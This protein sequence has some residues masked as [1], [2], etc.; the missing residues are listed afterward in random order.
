MLNAITDIDGIRVGHASDY[1][2]VTGC[3]V[4]LFD[5]PACCGIDI[6]GSAAGTRQI[7]AL[8]VAHIVDEAHAIMLAGGSAFGLDAASGVM[9]YLEERQTGYD[10]G[11]ARVPVV[12]AAVI[13]DLGIGDS[14]ARPTPQMAYDACITAGQA[15]EEGSVGAGVG[16]TVG[17]LF[18]LPRA[19]KGGVGTASVVLPDGT[20]VAALVVVN[21]FGDVIDNVTGK[22]IAGLRTAEDELTMAN[23]VSCMR[24]GQVRKEFGLYNTTLAVVAT[25]V[26]FNKREIGKV[27]QMAQGGLIK[28]VTPVHTTLDGDLVFSVSLGRMAG[29]VNRVG[30]VGEFVVSE[31][32]KRAVRK[33]DSL[34]KVPAFK[35]LPRQSKSCSVRGPRE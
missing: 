7:D 25:N 32:I 22:I 15:V 9:R 1:E 13:F 21:A 29:D 11:V 4:I 26:Q 30:V 24:E 33:A 8:N 28:T 23:T 2:G 34:G 3:T 18:G 20:I 17:K 16:A 35:D 19:M 31:A 14:R 27:A 10:V 6:R 12:P 5:G